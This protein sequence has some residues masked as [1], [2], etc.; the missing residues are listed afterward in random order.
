MSAYPVTYEVDYIEKRSRLSVLFRL[1]LLIP[2]AI[3]AYVVVIALLFSAIARWFAVVVTGR[4]PEGLYT[5][6]ANAARWLARYSAYAYLQVDK[7]PPFGFEDY[8]EYPLRM[9]SAGPL[10]QY[11][12]LKALFRLILGIPVAI[13]A[14][15]VSIV[16]SVCTVA[17]WFV[18]VIV[19]KMPRGLHEALD[20]CLA[21]FAKAYAY[22][23]LLTETYPPFSNE[24]PTLEP[25]G[26]PGE[27]AAR[28]GGSAPSVSTPSPRPG[29]LEG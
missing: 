26:T 6:N 3:V 29:G 27:L 14:Y 18:A 9:R 4:Y 2:H 1:L 5:F 7:Y 25:A 23:L 13:I 16:L 24:N 10:P 28:P 8:P 21:Y 12:R 22:F 15:V 11:S 20:F 19:G 17:A